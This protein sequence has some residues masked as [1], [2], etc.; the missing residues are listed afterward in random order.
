MGGSLAKVRA[1]GELAITAEEFPSICIL[2]A[3]HGSKYYIYLVGLATLYF[4]YEETE[5]Q[6][7]QVTY[8]RLPS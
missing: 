1:G 7:H 4:T 5:L 3:R 2:C 8:P 6:R